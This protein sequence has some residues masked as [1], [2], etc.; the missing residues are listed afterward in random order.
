MCCIPACKVVHMTDAGSDRGEVPGE[1]GA[2][3]FLWGLGEDGDL[4]GSRP[5][6]AGTH[7]SA[8]LV[9]MH[10]YFTH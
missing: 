9:R 6:H 7:R 2:R 3:A 4:Y 1:R 5:L 10:T 8:F